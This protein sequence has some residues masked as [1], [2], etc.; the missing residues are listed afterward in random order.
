MWI[1]TE[2]ESS[3][4]AAHLLATRSDEEL[5]ATQPSNDSPNGTPVTAADAAAEV[6]SDY[7]R[8]VDAD[9]LELPSEREHRI[10]ALTAQLDDERGAWMFER[11]SDYVNRSYHDELAQWCGGHSFDASYDDRRGVV[12]AREFLKDLDEVEREWSD[13]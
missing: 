11:S 1:S 2:A 12:I 9:E 7:F 4:Y 6:V 10:T 5:L 3:L 8:N 13:R